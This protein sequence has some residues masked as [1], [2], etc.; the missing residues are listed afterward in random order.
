MKSRKA[1]PLAAIFEATGRAGGLEGAT[2]QL[3]V[4]GDTCNQKLKELVEAAFHS[5]RSANQTNL[6]PERVEIILAAALTYGC[7][8]FRLERLLDDYCAREAAAAAEAVRVRAKT[9]FR[10]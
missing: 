10:S 5:V 7:A 2:V 4:A 9:R 1:P 6:P 3:Q 8:E